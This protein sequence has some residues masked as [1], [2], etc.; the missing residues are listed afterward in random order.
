MKKV[1]LVADNITSP[2]GATTTQ[3]FEHLVNGVSGVRQH[4]DK[5]LSDDPFFASLFEKV[6][7]QTDEYCTKFEHL[8]IA[9]LTETLH[10]VD[11]NISD[12]KTVLIISTT[13]GNISLLETEE[14]S[15][16][17]DAR[18]AL[19]TSAKKIARH[20][21]FV[22]EPIIVS[23]ACISGLVAM[24]TGMRLIQ[25]G[26]YDHAVVAGADVISKFVLSGFQSFQAVSKGLCKPFD[27]DRDGINL[28]EGA[29][30]V[31]LSTDK[32]TGEAI[33]LVSGAIS[34]DANHISGPSR[35]GEE[36]YYA[37]NK[38]MDAAGLKSEDID[39]ISAHGTATVYNDEME[40]KAVTLAGL[41]N[42]PLN[43][44]KGF[45]GHT[46][47]ASGLIEAIISAQSLKQNMIIPTK[48]FSKQGDANPVNVCSQL[49]STPLNSCLKIASGFGGCNAAI[50]LTKSQQDIS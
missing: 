30:T 41:Q 13:K 46:L 34:N 28:G 35:T 44:L 33:E 18:M 39:F 37:I 26:Q 27:A 8:L 1:Y 11:K 31:I 43:S 40:A 23:H 3:N 5:T 21:G 15:S 16:E 29:A 42:V 32:P 47:G 9:S 17:L 36:L 25:S 7:F 20:F 50:I 4:D 10:G 19:H 14:S 6:Y 12:K 2:L 22:N 38:A 49:I 24:I 48:G 45:Y